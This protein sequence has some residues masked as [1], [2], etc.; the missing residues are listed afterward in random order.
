[1][2][3]GNNDVKVYVYKFDNTYIE[4]SDLIS[5]M[6]YT[7]GLDKVSQQLDITMAYGIYSTAL[8]SIFFDTGQKIEV[9]INDVAYLKEK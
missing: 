8:P 7:C 9:Y 3:L 1:M 4:V 6:K 5:S 2:A